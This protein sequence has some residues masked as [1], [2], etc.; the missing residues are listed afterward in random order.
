MSEVHAIKI[1]CLRERAS[2]T[3]GRLQSP[4]VP[5]I[6]SWPLRTVPPITIPPGVRCMSLRFTAPLFLVLLA[7]PVARAGTSNSLLDV[8]P[9]GSRLLAV[10]AD[11]G[12]VSV[13]DLA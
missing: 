1:D 11:N 4:A 8:A 6:M 9:D 12:T 5:S 13:V 3:H 10:N 7:A 2:S